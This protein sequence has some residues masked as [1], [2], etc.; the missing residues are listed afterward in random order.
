MVWPTGSDEVLMVA[1]PLTTGEVPMTA[2]LPE[3]KVTVP[4]TVVG[5]VSVKVTET[6]EAEGLAEEVSFDDG[7]ALLTVRVVEADAVL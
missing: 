3:V 1:R 6:P 5:S 7:L 2:E 4:L